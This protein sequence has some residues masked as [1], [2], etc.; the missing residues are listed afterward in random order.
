MN[1]LKTAVAWIPSEIDEV[2]AATTELR[3]LAAARTSIRSAA[4]CQ[5]SFLHRKVTKKYTELDNPC[6]AA[7]PVRIS[8]SRGFRCGDP[9]VLR[10]MRLW[11]QFSFRRRVTQICISPLPVSITSEFGDGSLVLPGPASV[12]LPFDRALQVAKRPDPSTPSTL[13]PSVSLGST[14]REV[15][16]CPVGWVAWRLRQAP[17]RSGLEKSAM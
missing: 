17:I 13:H 9:E 11:H 16:A 15:C 4:P 10:S 14:R 1:D 8:R 3:G 6:D 12:E 2:K 7:R 5:H